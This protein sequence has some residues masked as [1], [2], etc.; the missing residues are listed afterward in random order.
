[1]PSTKIRTRPALYR[2]L[3]AILLLCAC[4]LA[5]AQELHLD[6]DFTDGGLRVGSNLD[7]AV[8]GAAPLRRYTVLLVDEA[9]DKVAT[10]V[11]LVA[12]DS[13]TIGRHRLWTRTGVVGCDPG[14]VHAPSS[15]LFQSFAEAESVLDGRTFRVLLVEGMGSPAATVLAE[16][17]LPMAAVTPFV[18]AWPSDGAGCLRTVLEAEPLHLAIRHR[19]VADETFRIFVVAPQ[20]VWLPGDPLVD[21]RPG[22]SQLTVVPAGADPWVELLWPVPVPGELQIIVRPGAD[23][24]ALFQATDVAVGTRVS[25]T[26]STYPECTVCPPPNDD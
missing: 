6:G 10:L 24:V 22:G 15:Y 18:S 3:F 20:A 7:V 14:V 21:V 19:S 23:T 8:T 26:G 12:D 1:M 4:Q 9:E 2:S 5:A 11:D 25:P 16:A 13:G 17:D